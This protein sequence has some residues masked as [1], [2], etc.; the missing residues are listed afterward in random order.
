MYLREGFVYGAL[1]RLILIVFLK[2]IADQTEWQGQIP[3]GG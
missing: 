1:H 3:Q 2:R